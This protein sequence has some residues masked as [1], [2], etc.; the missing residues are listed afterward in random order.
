MFIH[1]HFAQEFACTNRWLIEFC[2]KNPSLYAVRAIHVAEGP[3]QHVDIQKYIDGLGG[4][5]MTMSLYS[6]GR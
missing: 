3:K 2:R 4:E 1:K 6:Y 5:T